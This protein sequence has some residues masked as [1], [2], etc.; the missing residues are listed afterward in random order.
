MKDPVKA[1]TC[2]YCKAS[3]KKMS[4]EWKKII[5]R[6]LNKRRR[7]MDLETPEYINWYYA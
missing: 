4:T 5:K 3:K 6:S 1:C 2:E 7:K